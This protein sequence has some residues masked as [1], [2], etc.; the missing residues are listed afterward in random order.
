[1]WV[2]A[3]VVLIGCLFIWIGGKGC[4]FK[5]ETEAQEEENRIYCELDIG[6]YL[7]SLVDWI[8]FS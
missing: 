8:M 7:A 4:E 1:M 6:Y 3:T 5:A 2:V